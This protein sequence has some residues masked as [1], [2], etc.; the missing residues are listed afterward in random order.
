MIEKPRRLRRFAET[1]RLDWIWA[2]LILAT[3]AL[4]A[5]Q[6]TAGWLIEYPGTWVVPI[7]P[8]LNAFMQW[9]VDTVGPAFRAFSAAADVPMTAVRD[10]LNWLPW[11]VTLTLVT[12]A[13][14]A[15]ASWRLA[16]FAF[17]AILYMLVIGYWTESMNS[18]ALG[19]NHGSDRGCRRVRAGHA[20]V[21]LAARGAD[22][23]PDSGPDADG[24]GLRLSAAD[25]AAVRLRTRRGADR[26]HPL[27]LP[28]DG[29]QQRTW[30]CGKCR[31]RSSRPD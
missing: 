27:R 14:W 12:F 3:L 13:T 5:L 26:E 16:A 11:S 8:W 2:A 22:H 18:L 30:D 19:R 9:C 17:F 28:A 15:I 4:L 25:P 20:G 6:D 10:L 1:R 24:A 7:T 31:R 23:H 29:A 21:L